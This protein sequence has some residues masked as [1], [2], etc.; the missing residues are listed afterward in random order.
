LSEI[1]WMLSSLL[2]VHIVCRLKIIH[3]YLR[4]KNK[5]MIFSSQEEVNVF[6]CRTHAL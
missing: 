3:V 5:S 6:G 1:K 2:H 4:F